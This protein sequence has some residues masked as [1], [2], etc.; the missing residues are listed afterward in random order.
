MGFNTQMFKCARCGQAMTPVGG[1]N[2]T[3]IQVQ[4][5]G[6]A[7]VFSCINIDCQSVIGTAFVPRK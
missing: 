4:G 2:W 6:D 5:A 3:V 7:V 1:P